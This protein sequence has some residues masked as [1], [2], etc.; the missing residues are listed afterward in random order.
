MMETTGKTQR[1]REPDLLFTEMAFVRMMPMQ[2]F[3]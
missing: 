2:R 3:T 1:Q